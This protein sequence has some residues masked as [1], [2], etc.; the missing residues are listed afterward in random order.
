LACCWTAEKR[1]AEAVTNFQ[2]AL[3]ERRD[4]T[5]QAL[6]KIHF[7][8]GNALADLGRDAE[9]AGRSMPRPRG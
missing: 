4:L 9:S 8:L 6:G 7:E 2:M 5:A 3:R 1:P